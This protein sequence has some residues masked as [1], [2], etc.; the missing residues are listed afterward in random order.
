M[1]KECHRIFVSHYAELRRTLETPEYLSV[2]VRYKYLYK[3]A[4]VESRCRKA[5]AR[6]NDMAFLREVPSGNH[7]ESTRL[8]ARG[9]RVDLRPDA[10]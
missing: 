7:F 1:T 5:L 4:D 6:V 9:V 2:Y 10:P 8:R 3:G